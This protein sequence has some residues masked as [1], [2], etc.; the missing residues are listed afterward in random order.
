MHI[1]L[2]KIQHC[3]ST[4]EAKEQRWRHTPSR[5]KTMLQSYSNQNSTVLTQSQTY[6]LV[7]KNREPRNKPI[8]IRTQK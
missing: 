1:Y 2:Q 8:C 5:L 7:G 3:Q 6:G 4:P